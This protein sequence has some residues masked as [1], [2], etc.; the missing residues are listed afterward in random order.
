MLNNFYRLFRTVVTNKIC[1]YQNYVYPQT[2]FPANTFRNS[3]EKKCTD[4][5]RRPSTMLLP[6]I[7]WVQCSAKKPEINE[8]ITNLVI[9]A[10]Q[11]INS[12]NYQE[13]KQHL[14][15]ALEMSEKYH[16]YAQVPSIFDD[17]ILISKREGTVLEVEELLI[18]FIEKL[19]L[20]GF[21]ETDN[22]ILRYKLKLSKL[23]HVVGNTEIA[24]LGFR[25]CIN[26][27]EEKLRKEI[28]DPLTNSIYI[29]SLFWYG[30]F[31]TEE[32]DLDRAKIYLK[33]ALDFTKTHEKVLTPN[34]I[35]VIL[36]H[37]AEVAFRLKV[38]IN[39]ELFQYSYKS[40]YRHFISLPH[41]CRNTT[42]R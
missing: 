7:V 31:L 35:M 17:L 20:I 8:M 24:E 25:D 3:L 4:P 42:T 33:K 23:Y 36:Y 37:N 15:S 38:R 18:R 16:M 21:K 10:N 39:I 32:D 1:R 19:I 13:A 26:V 30:R 41:I 22:S 27:L 2:R 34:Q 5:M 9:K 40:I 28:E 6:A 11:A 14:N 12:G 29:S